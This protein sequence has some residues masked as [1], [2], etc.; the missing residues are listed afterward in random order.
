MLLIPHVDQFSAVFSVR[1]FV[2]NIWN[3]NLF[4]NPGTSSMGVVSVV[5][6]LIAANQFHVGTFTINKI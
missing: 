3:P 1:A 6:N 4:K 2:K 5:S